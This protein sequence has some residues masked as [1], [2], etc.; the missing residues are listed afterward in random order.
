MPAS[1]S[2]QSTRWRRRSYAVPAGRA[3]W[4]AVGTALLRT[5]GGLT[6]AT[7]VTL[8]LVPVLYATFVLDLKLVKCK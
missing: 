6:I 8:L 3:L 1:A 5:I 2:A 4:S 7:F